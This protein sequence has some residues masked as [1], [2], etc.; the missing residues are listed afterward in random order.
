MLGASLESDCWGSLCWLFN[1]K[2]EDCAKRIRILAGQ[3]V[4]DGDRQSHAKD[5]V[6]SEQRNNIVYKYDCKV[7]LPILDNQNEHL[8]RELKNTPEL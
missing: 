3:P 6:P 1:S 5:P 8:Q 7:R 4:S 2:Y